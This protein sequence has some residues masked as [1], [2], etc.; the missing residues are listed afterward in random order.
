[1]QMTVSFKCYRAA[2]LGE[3]PGWERTL[4]RE[5]L[6]AGRPGPEAECPD[7]ALGPARVDQTAAAGCESATMAIAYRRA[8]CER[9]TRAMPREPMSPVW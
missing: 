1:M 5:A 8:A 4:G 9:P 6:G 3:A 7:E 2:R